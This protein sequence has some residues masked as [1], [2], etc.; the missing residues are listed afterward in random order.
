MLVNPIGWFMLALAA[1]LLFVGNV[2][3]RRLTAIA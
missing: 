1:L 2:I 3:I